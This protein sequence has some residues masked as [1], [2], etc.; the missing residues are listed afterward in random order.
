MAAKKA[1]TLNKSEEI[2]KA[3][4]QYPDKA[5]AEI[6]RILTERLGVPF[7]RKAVSSIKAKMGSRPAQAPK[8]AA[9]AAARKTPPPRPQPS[10]ARAATTGAVAPMVANLQAYI[11]RVGKEDLHQLID[12]L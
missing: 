1:S 5:P 3:L 7:R 8:P 12:T 11:K 10:S 6:A 9:P 4:G 2:R